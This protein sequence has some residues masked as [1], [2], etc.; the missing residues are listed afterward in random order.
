MTPETPHGTSY[1]LPDLDGL[2]G[3]ESWPAVSSPKLTILPTAFGMLTETG[4]VSPL[5]R[6]SLPWLMG[7]DKAS[8]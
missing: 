7:H 4:R 5:M 3:G 8:L 2:I 6:T 1:R